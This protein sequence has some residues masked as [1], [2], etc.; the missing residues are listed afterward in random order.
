M[1]EAI[2]Y[3][4]VLISCNFIQEAVVER[5]FLNKKVVFIDP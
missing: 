4:I 1:Q 5:L 3:I 2:Q